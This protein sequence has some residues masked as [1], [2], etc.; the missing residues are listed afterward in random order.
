MSETL[1]LIS[2]ALC[3]LLSSTVARGLV[4][5][6]SERDGAKSAPEEPA[7]PARERS[8]E[9]IASV[10]RDPAALQEAHKALEVGHRTFCRT[11]R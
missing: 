6:L 3:V 7:G 2:P 8:M 10:Q 11:R 1:F 5:P 9:K 4:Q